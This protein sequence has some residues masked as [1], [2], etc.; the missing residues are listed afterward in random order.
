M[1]VLALLAGCRAPEEIMSKNETKVGGRATVL[2]PAEMVGF[3]VTTDAARSRAF[4]VD[5][6][7]F[8]VVGED[9]YAL[10][11]SADGRM[12]RIQ[13]GANHEPRQGTV[14]GWNVPDIEATVSRLLE[15]GVRCESYGF[16]GQDA[17]GI[18]TF[19][20]GARVAWFKDPDGNLL[21]V[22]Q[23]P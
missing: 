11:L 15:A 13:K 12:I 6:L 19:P 4:F 20:D 14:L 23:L 3:L 10:V 5:R 21:S 22:S 16:P 7:G 17:R 2:H 18:M 9:A 8:R 1:L